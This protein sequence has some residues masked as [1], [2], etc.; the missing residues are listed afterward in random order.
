MK[1]TGAFNVLHA[2]KDIDKKIDG[3]P[4]AGY[5]CNKT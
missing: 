2:T 1:T 3:N 4:N 5:G